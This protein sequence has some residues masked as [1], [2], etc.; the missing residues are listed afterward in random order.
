MMDE[1]CARASLDRRRL[2][3]AHLKYAALHVYTWYP[4]F[5]P[6]MSMASSIQQILADMTPTFYTAFSMYYSCK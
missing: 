2:E 4:D 1:I 6:V 3:E 5:F